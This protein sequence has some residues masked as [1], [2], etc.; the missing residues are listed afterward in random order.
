MAQSYWRTV[1]LVTMWQISASICYYSVFAATPFFRDAFGLSRFSVGVV[2]TMVTLGYAVFLLPLGALV[3]RFGERL[4]LSLS[5]VGLATGAALVAGSPTYAMLLAAVFVLG[6]LYGT[7]MPGTNKA[8]FDNIEPGKQNLAM[9]IKQVG[10]TGG[11]GIS[12]LLVTGLAGV[13]F[14]QA[15]F[16]IATALGLVVAVVF[17]RLYSSSS[18]GG[19]A[20]YPD[21]RVLLSN[22]PYV[23]LTVAGLFLGAALFTTTGYTVLYVEESIGASV[24]F[25]GVVLALVQLFGSVGRV[26]TGW[27]ADVLPGDPQVRIGSILIVQSLAGAVLFVVVASTTTVLG[28][29]LAFSALGFFV[30]GY[31]G[32]YYS[33]MATL[34][35]AEE[36]GG[37]TAGGQLA[38]T[39]GALFAPPAFGYL[40][41]TIGYRASWLLLAGL[42]LVASGLLVLVTRTTTPVSR[43]AAT[44]A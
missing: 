20:E 15:G 37:A 32:V 11:S 10:V 25:S 19:T 24:A 35:R 21:F 9:G 34:V 38:L 39:S 4:T 43:P 7:A 23:L 31:T 6:S 2:V 41:D 36:M 44:D 8:V 18:A 27:L 42:V 3:D 33:V 12:A 28:A 30:L 40:A 26:L 22:Q 17:Y 29:T 5:L 1:S 16:L 14:W 13:L